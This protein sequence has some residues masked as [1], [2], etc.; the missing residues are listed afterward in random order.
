MPS[1]SGDTSISTI[2][3]EVE[4][5][6]ACIST[7]SVSE[8]LAETIMVLSAISPQDCEGYEFDAH[9]GFPNNSPTETE[10]IT[11]ADVAPTMTDTTTFDSVDVTNTTVVQTAV[12]TNTST[13]STGHNQHHTNCGSDFHYNSKKNC[14]S[15]I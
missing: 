7:A 12:I 11:V 2:S 15:Y 4:V 8:T 6:Q 3:D 1:T 13:N 9:F 10:T 5:E 14:V